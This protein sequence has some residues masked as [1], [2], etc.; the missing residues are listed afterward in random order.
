[1]NEPNCAVLAAIEDGQLDKRRLDSFHKLL[2]E[3]EFA[4][5]SIAEKRAKDRSFGK[6][7]KGVMAHKQKT[8]R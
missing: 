5:A 4:T 6:M 8:G 7:I 2:R 3:N 1:M